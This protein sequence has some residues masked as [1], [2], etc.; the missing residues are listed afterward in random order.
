METCRRPVYRRRRRPP[1][2]GFEANRKT[3]GRIIDYALE[4]GLNTR[5][6]TVEE[7]FDRTTMKLGG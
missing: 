7:L 6:F 3:I 5:R 1:P 4:Q 2:L